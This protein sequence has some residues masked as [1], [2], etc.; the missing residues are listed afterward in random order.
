MA[1]A[2]LSQDPLPNFNAF[3]YEWNYNISDLPE[4]VSAV[5]VNGHRVQITKN[6]AVLLTR[7]R[8]IRQI[9]PD[10]KA[11]Q[12]PIWIDALC[13]DQSNA[14]ERNHQVGLMGA[15]YSG[16]KAT[17][18]WLG[19]N[20]NDSDYAMGMI[21]EIGSKIIKSM[22]GDIMA[23]VD[24]EQQPELWQ[25]DKDDRSRSLNRFWDSIGSLMKRSYWKRAWI[26]QEILLQPNVI[27]FC[28]G[29]GLLHYHQLNAVQYWLRRIQGKPCPRGVDA[30]LWASLSSQI[31]WYSMGWNNFLTRRS[32]KDPEGL[33]LD[34]LDETQ[35]HMRW[36]TWVLQTISQQATDP[37]DNLYS[38]LG[39]VGVDSLQPDYSLSAES[40]FYDFATTN[41]RIE[42]SLSILSHAG[43]WELPPTEDMGG[44]APAANLFVPSWVPNWDQISKMY[45]FS[46]LL[47]ANYEADKSWE[48][49]LIMADN[50]VPW[51]ISKNTLVTPGVLF[52]V[53]SLTR[54]CDMKD[55]SWMAFCVDRL[56]A[57]GE[58][59]YPSGIPIAQALARLVLRGRRWPDREL[60]ER[61]PNL[62]TIVEKIFPWFQ[63]TL[64]SPNST[65]SREFDKEEA[66]EKLGLSTSEGLL[67]KLVGK[68]F[69]TMI[70][71]LVPLLPIMRQI[72][73]DVKIPVT[74]DD[75]WP[76][77]WA[78][79]ANVA[80]NIADGMG[81]HV[82]FVTSKG[83]L[84]W[85][86]RG[87]RNGDRVCILPNCLMPVLLRKVDSHSI[88][89]GTGYVE[90]LMQGEA[91]SC[92]R[93]GTAHLETFHIV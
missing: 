78:D 22:G 80:K 52:D 54:V 72:S 34:A 29:G 55:G 88:N 32:F 24:P 4:I 57:Q 21:P 35:R 91:I 85:G 12:M 10:F 2:S 49:L 28:G 6:L 47:N 48:S 18:T 39:I 14:Q 93:D 36:K 64:R 60:L 86:R 25:S 33:E 76:S 63:A 16:A 92:V 77:L 75:P 89:L 43:H 13:I 59:P 61:T 90:G 66:L 50:Q 26:V 41:I 5:I 65:R 37:R 40:V 20:E 31:G 51:S 8:N 27:I 11:F 45:S 87:L 23:W 46:W 30:T 7:Y 62:A 17:L 70:H 71:E 9:I 74:A 3:S 1:K 19:E 67:E 83:Y 82:A 58:R 15:I 69:N 42:N 84:G 81:Q 73:A 44:T 79:T 56:K 68:P 53:V 38:V